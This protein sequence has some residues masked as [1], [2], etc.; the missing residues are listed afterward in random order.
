MS[1]K[2][3]SDDEIKKRIKQ[4]GKVLEAIANTSVLPQ[5]EIRKLIKEFNKNSEKAIG[6]IEERKLK[7]NKEK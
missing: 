6:F 2:H 5:D 4:N 3:L 7:L 1:L